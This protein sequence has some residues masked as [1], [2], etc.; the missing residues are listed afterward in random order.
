MAVMKKVLLVFILLAPATSAFAS[1]GWYP[2]HPGDVIETEVCLPKSVS[3]PIYLQLI[4]DKGSGKTVAKIYFKDLKAD[5]YCRDSIKHDPATAGPYHLKYKWS[6]NV[7]GEN[8]LQFFNPKIKKTYYGWPDGI[9][10]T[11]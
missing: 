7:T 3:S 2:T 9:A 11:R 8:G 5:S 4:P 10:S 6:V 1:A